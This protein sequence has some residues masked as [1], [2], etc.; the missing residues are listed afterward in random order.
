M[1]GQCGSCWAFAA[2]ACQET[3][4]AI[5][6]GKL[7]DL[8][9]Q[10]LMNCNSEG[11]NCDGGYFKTVELFRTE[12]AVLESDEPYQAAAGG[13]RNNPR[14]YRIASWLEYMFYEQIVYVSSPGTDPQQ[15]NVDLDTLIKASIVKYG[16]CWVTV[17]VSDAFG[18]YSGGIYDVQTSEFPDHAVQAVGYSDSGRY[19]IIKNS[20]D[21]NWGEEGFARIAYGAANFGAYSGAIVYEQ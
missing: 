10:D 16:S 20:W 3:S 6:C 21:K 17:K 19:W 5:N 2:V 14:N 4:V 1:Q 18:A 7:T 8:S 9:E 13:C 15:V 11:Q 12:G